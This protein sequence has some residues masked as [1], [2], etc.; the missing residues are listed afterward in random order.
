MKEREREHSRETEKERKG[1]CM[2]LIKTQR[3]TLLKHRVKKELSGE[4]NESVFKLEESCI[5]H[6]IDGWMDGWM[7]EQ[8]TKWTSEWATFPFIVFILN[9]FESWSC[10]QDATV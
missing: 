1:V 7:V 3:K 9:P 6:R 4:K 2:C 8:K 5:P 10:G